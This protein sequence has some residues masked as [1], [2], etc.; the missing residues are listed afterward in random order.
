MS[1]V[2]SFTVVY[3]IPNFF[4]FL[5]FMAAPVAF[6]PGVKLEL[7]LSAYAT[8]TAVQDPIPVY[9]LY[10]SSW[11]GQILNPLSKARDR[12]GNLMVPSW[13]RFHC[14]TMGTPRNSYISY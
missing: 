9:D 10:H 12:T 1:N 11:Q 13:I 2:N 8:A 7:Q 6:E 14:T 3:V 5:L 4:F